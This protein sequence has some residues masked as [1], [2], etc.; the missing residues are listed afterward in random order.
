MR[1]STL[2]S[3]QFLN[4]DLFPVILSDL[5][6]KFA[7]LPIKK[8]FEMFSVANEAVWVCGTC[9]G[10]AHHAV[11]PPLVADPGAGRRAQADRVICDTTPR[12][13]I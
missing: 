7:T 4:S 12:G 13:Y 8:I 11:L 10:G 9:S 2:F 6:G 3:V 5:T 1:I